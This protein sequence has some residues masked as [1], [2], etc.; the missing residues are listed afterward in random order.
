M[1][2]KPPNFPN[3][4]DPEK[5]KRGAA[6][7]SV[8]AALFLVLVKLVVGLETNSLGI[9]SEAAHSG[10]DLLAAGITY[11]AVRYASAP[12]DPHHPY[13]HGKME[14]LSA[15]VETI[16]LLLTCV[17]IVW[18]A[19]HRLFVRPAEVSVPWWSF[20]VV[21]VSIGVD[22]TR[23]RML[24]RMAKKHKS[25]ALEAD[26]LHFSTDIWASAVVLL[27]LACVWAAGMLPSGAAL[28]PILERADAVAA[29]G[30]SVIIVWVSLR[31]GRAAV[32]VLLDGDA[33][34]VTKDIRTAALGVA[35]V[36]G[37]AQVRA[38][39]S[40]P[41]AFVDISVEIARETSFE[42]AHGIGDKVEAAVRAVLPGADVVVH[43][44]PVA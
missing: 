27:G 12:A 19:A 18:E 40:G 29:L 43:L 32:E 38:R 15:L 16:L 5:E 35:G 25:Q 41:A 30:V 44:E 17:Y 39:L 10:L 31:L 14:N 23:S 4:V 3:S 21:I 36:R 28:R 24:K 13:G 42:G 11:F 37:V 22:V 6:L 8:A 33:Q 2:S 20:G 7:S 9:L 34:G 1:R 26:A